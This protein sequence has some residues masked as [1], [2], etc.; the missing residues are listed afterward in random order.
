MKKNNKKGFTIVELV[1]VIAVIGILAGVLIPTF[2][3]VVKKARLSADQQAV[4]QMNTELAMHDD[5][6]NFADAKATLLEAN[7]DANSYKPLTKNHQFY[8]VKDLNRVVLVSGEG[9]VVYPDNL[10]EKAQVELDA[11]DAVSLSGE[12]DTAKKEE[13]TSAIN[14]GEK[15]TGIINMMGASINIK[16]TA[17]KTVIGGAEGAP[18]TIVDL[19]SDEGNLANASA[20]N[21]FANNLYYAGLVSTVPAGKTVVVEN[22]VIDGAVVGDSSKALSETARNGIIAGHV[23]GT[24]IIRNVTIKNSIVFGGYR[25]GALVGSM[26]GTGKVYIENVTL[27][28]VTVKGGTNTAALIGDVKED[29]VVKFAGDND[30]SGVT[31]VALPMEGTVGADERITYV[32]G[33]YPNGNTTCAYTTTK[34]FWVQHGYTWNDKADQSKGY[35]SNDEAMSEDWGTYDWTQVL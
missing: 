31:V 35:V 28:N 15:L 30:F 9:K 27:E 24:L 1:I 19:V 34:Y 23:E 17:T 21:E 26:K 13:V 11:K 12:G 32:N 10:I 20:N 5:I 4:S 2:S 25:V 14:A 7:I 16:P 29:S 6:D 22:L 33:A 8:Y 3:N 18:A